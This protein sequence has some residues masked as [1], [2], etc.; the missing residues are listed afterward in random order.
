MKDEDDNYHSTFIGDH[1]ILEKCIL[2]EE[3]MNK[4][5]KGTEHI[6]PKEEH[7]HLYS[8]MTNQTR[9]ELLKFIDTN[10]RSFNEIKENFQLDDDQLQY[11]LSMLE[12]LFFLINMESGW[13][14]TP[15]GLGFLYYTILR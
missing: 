13:K 5:L 12:Q 11:H 9:R 3:E 1:D 15:R 4:Y 14:A 8:V 6:D 7:D 10:A 2:D